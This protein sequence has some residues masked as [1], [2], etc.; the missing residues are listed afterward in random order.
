[1]EESLRGVGKIRKGLESGAESIS[2][3]VGS[4]TDEG[5]GAFESTGTS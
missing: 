3:I 1:M 4:G 5:S 2:R